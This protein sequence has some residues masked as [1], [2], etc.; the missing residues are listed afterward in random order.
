[1][2]T[3]I[4]I[5]VDKIDSNAVPGILPEEKDHFL[6][7]AQD[8]VKK[9]RYGGKNSYRKGFEQSQKRIDDL[10]EIVVRDMGGVLPFIDENDVYTYGLPDNYDFL[11]SSRIFVCEA[12]CHGED[13]IDTT[14]YGGTDDPIGPAPPTE[15][16]IGLPC[17]RCP[18]TGS[19]DTDPH[20][21]AP[22]KGEDEEEE[23]EEQDNNS[24]SGGSRTEKQYESLSAGSSGDPDLYYGTQYSRFK[25]ISFGDLNG[26]KNVNS[27][28]FKGIVCRWVRP[29]QVSHDKL[30]ELLLDPFNKPDVNCPLFVFEGNKIYYYCNPA[31]VITQVEITY[32]RKLAR[33]SSDTPIVL[34]NV[35]ICELAE[36]MHQEVVDEAVD[37]ILNP[38]E[39]PRI[40]TQKIENLSME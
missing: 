17:P 36:H 8:R 24:K 12:D 31:F 10:R 20:E 39:S 25:A 21:P 23:E 37:L 15:P 34:P 33:L 9:R 35:D 1:M 40:Q 2:H 19:P 3:S 14:T 27:T 4:E 38:I 30:R 22:P 28:Y 26:I 13:F 16:P 18:D 5:G 11:I 7:R 6:N 32:L 29:K